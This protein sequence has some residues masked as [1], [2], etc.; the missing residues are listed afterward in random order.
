MDTNE[1]RHEGCE[2]R[3]VA[4]LEALDGPYRRGA[5]VTK[6][7]HIKRPAFSAS[8]TATWR[9]LQGDLRRRCRASTTKALRLDAVVPTATIR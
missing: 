4:A 6:M 7:L 9:N 5:V 3:L 1:W 2:Q 8:A